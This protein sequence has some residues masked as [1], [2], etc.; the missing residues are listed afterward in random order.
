MKYWDANTIDRIRKGYYSAAYFNRT[1][2]ILEKENEGTSVTMQIFQRNDDAVLCG[3][4]EV[5]ALLKAGSGYWKGDKWTTRWKK[6][7]VTSLCDGDTIKSKESVMHI[8]GPYVYFAHLESLYLGILAR[9]TMVATN[10]RRVVE[11]ASGKP[12]ICFSDR[13]DHFLNQ[14]GD[15]YAA[16]LGGAMGVCTPAHA[17]RWNGAPSGTIPHALIAVNGGNTVEAALQF[18]KNFPDI[19]LISLV[20]YANDCVGTALS[21]AKALKRRLWAVRL[22]TSSD[23]VDASITSRSPSVRGVTPE[24]VQNVR[25]VL[26]ENGFSRVKIVVSGGFNPDKIRHFER[27]NVPTDVYGVGSALLKGGNDF[28]ADIVMVNGAHEAKL[29]RSYRTNSRFRQIT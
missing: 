9:R 29:G 5:I 15:G 20:D 23:V 25:K 21:V 12:V 24:L 22:D 28:T 8:S 2:E 3:V 13:F 26:N 14:E 27:S 7:R 17:S 4:D 6:L 16:H 1:K 18:A 19:P 11:A 10:T